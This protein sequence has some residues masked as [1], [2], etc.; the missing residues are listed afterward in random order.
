M[1]ENKILLSIRGLTYFVGERRLLDIPQL[2][3][4]ETDHIGIVGENGCGKSTL[5]DLMAGV[6]QPE[7][8]SIKRYCPL[9]YCRQLAAADLSAADVPLAALGAGV[10]AKQPGRSGGEETRVKLAAALEEQAPTWTRAGKK[11]SASGWPRW[12]RWYW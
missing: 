11:R 4:T 12:R 5:L 3:I 2:H 1:T 9:A 6:R 8:G 10:L 7:S